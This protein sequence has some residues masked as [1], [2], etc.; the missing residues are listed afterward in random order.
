MERET[1]NK[2]IICHGLKE[3]T[4]RTKIWKIA[5]NVECIKALNILKKERERAMKL[6][7]VEDLNT[8]AKQIYPWQA[9]KPVKRCFKS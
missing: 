7:V 5:L 4:Y 6:T 8:S 1:G 3:D 2:K 9:G